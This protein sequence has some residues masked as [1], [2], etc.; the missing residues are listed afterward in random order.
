MGV[1]KPDDL[2]GAVLRGIDM[3]DCVLPT[4]SGRHGQAFTWDGPINLRNAAF[5]EDLSPLDAASSCRASNG[6]S[7][8]YLH[9]LARAGEMLAAVILSW[10]NIAFYQALMSGLRGA[11][12]E[13]T[14]RAFGR[15]FLSRYRPGSD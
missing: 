15:D 6:F 5:S 8:A 3:F 12:Q 7:R 2:V 13:G 4:R 14:A 1:G 10:H 11:C 9:H